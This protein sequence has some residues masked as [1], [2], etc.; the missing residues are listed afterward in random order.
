MGRS[1]ILAED[2][3][4][5][6]EYAAE[7]VATLAALPVSDP[8][9]AV[10]RE[11]AIEAWLPMASRLARRYAR[12]GELSDDLRQTATIGL[13]KAV[14]GYD[15]GRGSEFVSYAIPTIVGEIKRY[16]RD[17]TWSVRVPRRLQEM[18]LLIAQARAELGQT[19]H[20][21]PTVADIALHLHVSEEEVL[22]GLESEYAYRAVSLSRPVGE[23]AS[24]ELGDTLG[25]HDPGYA[26]VE[27]KAALPPALSRLTERE[28]RIIAMRFYGNQT[29]ASIAE[30]IGVSQMHVSRILAGALGKLR[31]HLTE[32]G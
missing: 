30:Q 8:D 17:R 29:Q 4:V 6:D 2:R 19:S 18:R 28:R 23:D 27:L 7:L 10:V 14:D 11:R 31:G 3:A 12:R 32:A 26:L 9:R 21:S 20:R 22:E 16:F 1:T 25:A 15:P 5:E 24:L 13:I